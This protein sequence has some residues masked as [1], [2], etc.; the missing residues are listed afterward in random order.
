MKKK[1]HIL[2]T[3]DN[4]YLYKTDIKRWI[5]AMRDDTE[6]ME[7][8]SKRSGGKVSAADIAEKLD[9]IERGFDSIEHRISNMDREH[10]GYI[11]ATVTRL[12]YLLNQDDNTKGLVIQLLNHLSEGEQQEDR[13]REVGERMNLSQMT[14]LS[15]KSLYKR[16]RPKADFTVNLEAEE[17]AEEL[18]REEILNLNKLK[19]RYSKKEIESFI[20]EKMEDGRMEVT[21][22]MVRSGED[23][24]KLILAY[25]YSTRRKSL[26]RVEEADGEPEM[27]ESGGYR[28][29]KL[30]F[31]RRSA[32]L[33]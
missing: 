26:Y 10:S 8:M 27:I 9:Q 2:K 17:E 32:K 6:W 5:A 25:D 22:D 31:V 12:N 16:R 23:F 19:N 13:I 1:Y 30:T 7:Q 21:D 4:F 28:Y 24:E 3:S 11:R 14:I 20:E 18:S 33:V 29:P 15:E